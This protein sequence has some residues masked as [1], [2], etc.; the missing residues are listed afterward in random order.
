MCIHFFFNIVSCIPADKLKKNCNVYKI[1]Y[2]FEP[3]QYQ[4]L[5]HHSFQPLLEQIVRSAL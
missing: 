2:H 4:I 5:S 1:I 3:N